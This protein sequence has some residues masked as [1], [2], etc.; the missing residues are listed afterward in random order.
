VSLGEDGDGLP[1]MEMRN[2][3]VVIWRVRTRD[4][5]VFG[6]IMVVGE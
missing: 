3:M 5:K 4:V 2:V 6:S 1:E